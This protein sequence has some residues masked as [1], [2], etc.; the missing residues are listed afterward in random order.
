MPKTE[1]FTRKLDS[2]VTHAGREVGRKLGTAIG[3][4]GLYEFGKHVAEAFEKSEMATLKLE[5][6][7]EKF[8]K[9]ASANVEEFKNLNK[10]LQLHT[11][12]SDED[13]AA[14]EATLARFNL[15]ADQ[16]KRL[17]PLTADFAAVTGQDLQSAS[18]SLGRAMLGNARALKQLGIT[19]HATGDTAKD[20]ETIMT[21]V[22]AKVG[23]FAEKQAQTAGGKLKV[24]QNQFQDLETTIGGALVPIMGTLTSA[25]TP[26]VSVLGK[27]PPQFFSIAAG[28]GAAIFG[29]TKF[30]TAMSAAAGEASLMSVSL[31]A[32]AGAAG[33]AAAGITSVSAV[34]DMLNQG[35][36]KYVTE[37]APKFA[38]G[39]ADGTISLS[40]FTGA[41]HAGRDGWFDLGSQLD[42]VGSKVDAS[43]SG[44][45]GLGSHYDELTIKVLDD[46]KAL[47]Y[48]STAL[49]TVNITTR[50]AANQQDRLT[51][52]YKKTTDAIKR[53]DDLLNASIN[54]LLASQQAQD[55]LT[56]KMREMEK[57]Y[58][59]GKGKFDGNTDAA[60]RNRA[61]LRGLVTQILTT[62][63]AMRASGE[64]ANTDAAAKKRNI[65]QLKA[66]KKLF[67]ELT[68]IINTYID[69]LKH[70]IPTT[71]K[72]TAE[73]DD[74]TAQGRLDH[75]IYNLQHG[76]PQPF[77]LGSAPPPGGATGN[78][79]RAGGSI[80]VGE[81]HAETFHADRN[82]AIRPEQRT[83]SGGGDVYHVMI[84]INGAESPTE[85]RRAVRQEMRDL[86]NRD[87][88]EE[89]TG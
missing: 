55:D 34:S 89:R 61:I 82:G 48:H 78:T 79:V 45:L 18:I 50:T 36:N 76:L 8:P 40:E 25:V 49:G 16:L 5:H 21:L 19:F 4:F 44:L 42:D 74:K 52:A 32:I 54:P 58:A 59:H 85:V 86:Q 17:V 67:P 27:I 60:I 33:I 38:K 11:I 83:A 73:F 47:G 81:H 23:G 31:G 26:V 22:S 1:G 15:T 9:L 41:V 12:Y 39:L 84:E 69:L 37:N 3:A 30:E 7:F 72:T 62:T 29:I 35:A 66:M 71:V 57:A 14:A 88:L 6:A 64:I 46:L 68:P 20:F 75:W 2:Q 13:Y 28:V 24:L 77:D 65:D 70:G 53:F 87:S 10:Q 56:T 43:G 80:V 63:D 51:G